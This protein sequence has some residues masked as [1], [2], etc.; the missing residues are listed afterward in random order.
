MEVKTCYVSLRKS[1]GSTLRISVPLAPE[2]RECIPMFTLVHCIYKDI[3][4][5]KKY[6]LKFHEKKID[7]WNACMS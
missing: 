2:M 3:K 1:V 5:S 4:I 6:H 7:E